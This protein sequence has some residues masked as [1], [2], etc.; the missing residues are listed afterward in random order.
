MAATHT[1]TVLAVLR[2][3]SVLPLFL[4]SCV[5]RLPMGAFGLL[6]VLHTK[7]LTGSYG[8]GGVAAGVFTLCVA[9]STPVLA[10]VGDKHGQWLVLRAGAIIAAAAMTVLALLPSGAPLGVLLAASALAGVAQPPTGACMRALWPVLV[11]D[12]ARRH[13]AYA[14]ES[15]I[16]EVVYMFGPVVIVAGIGS[17]SLE[18]ALLFCAGCELVGNLAFSFHPASRGWRPESERAAGAL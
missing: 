3:P 14:L 6:L 13:A 17:W 1:E 8:Q 5:A 10:R 7:D 4:A 9:I 15:V 18:A 16:L 2:L 11:D 12:P